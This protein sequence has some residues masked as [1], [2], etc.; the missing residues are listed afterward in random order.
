M[1]SSNLI[2]T[3]ALHKSVQTVAGSLSILTN[4]NM[5]ISLGTTAAIVGASGSGKTTL[6][7]LLAGLDVPTTG[8]CWFDG[9]EIGQL[10]EDARAALRLQRVGFVF[11]SFHLLA[12]LTAQENVMLAL[13]ITGAAD[14]KSRADEML[15]QV[16]LGSR[17]QHYPKQLSGG[18]QQRVALARAFI[19]QPKVIFAD[20][21]T[22]NLDDTN[23]DKIVELMFAMNE[24][25]Q[26]TLII[27]THSQQLAKRC[28]EQYQLSHGEI[29]SCL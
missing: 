4:I 8:E 23:S 3:K 9:Q 29:A 6:L 14:A 10:D 17:L 1:A 11:Q 20:E 19:T 15:A 24:Q 25:H 12:G 13:E 22:G 26:T 27:V 18:E 21:P 16:G 28:H 5:K 7:G 2:E